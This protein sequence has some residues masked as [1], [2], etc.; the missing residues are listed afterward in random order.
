MPELLKRYPRVRCA[1][2]GN[3]NK[4]ESIASLKY[5]FVVAMLAMF[6]LLTLEFRSYMQPLLILIIIPFGFIGAAL[7]HA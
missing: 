1:G 2:R 7:G 6:A 4:R 3:K 5:G